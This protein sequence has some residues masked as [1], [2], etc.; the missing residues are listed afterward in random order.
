MSNKITIQKCDSC[1]NEFQEWSC[2]FCYAKNVI[3]Q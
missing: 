2:D 3:G 1:G